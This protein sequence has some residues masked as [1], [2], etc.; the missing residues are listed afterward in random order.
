MNKKVYYVGVDTPGDCIA[1]DKLDDLY[2]HSKCPCVGHKLD[3]VFVVHSPI[4]FEIYVDRKP[5]ENRI[6]CTDADLMEFDD[7]YFLSPNP[8][9][10]LM[11]AQFLFW[12]EEDDIWFEF[13]DHPM[14]SLNNNFVAIGGWF[15]LS[16]W[17]RTSS[18]AFTVV[19]ET[20]PV[21]IKKGDP[22][23]RI[24][25]YPPDL[26]DGIILQE[27]K[28]SRISEEIKERYIKKKKKEKPDDWRSK[29]FSRTTKTSKC[30]VSFLFDRGRGFQ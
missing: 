3:R 5:G 10:Q 6:T 18:L 12:T 8:V 15:N 29:L 22:V 7:D 19:D 28:D 11:I 23:S 14:T 24:R 1:S 21:I 16:N 20:K 26:R 4:D 17:S 13:N 27:E 2:V 9:L 25:F 30:P